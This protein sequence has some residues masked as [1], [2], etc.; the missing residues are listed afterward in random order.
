MNHVGNRLVNRRYY[1]D[2]HVEIFTE[3][4]LLNDELAVFEINR[5][6]GIGDR[7]LF[8]FVKVL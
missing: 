3:I 1:F 5:L 4:A 7:E 8:P 6:Q 2:D